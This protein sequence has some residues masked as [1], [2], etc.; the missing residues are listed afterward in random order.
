MPGAS[1]LDGGCRV[2]PASRVAAVEIPN[3]PAVSGVAVTAECDGEGELI[4]AIGD[5][6]TAECFPD[7]V[8]GRPP[9]TSQGIRI[10]GYFQVSVS[11]GLRPHLGA[12]RI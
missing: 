2:N 3:E 5:V 4:L 7:S 9:A 6:H 8:P 12:V 11:G 10:G 1:A